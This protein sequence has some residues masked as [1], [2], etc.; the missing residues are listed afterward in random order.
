[1]SNPENCPTEQPNAEPKL[2]RSGRE[3]KPPDFYGVRV[4]FVSQSPKEPRSIKEAIYS[5]QKSQ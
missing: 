2:R 3:R 1:M 5:P 4:N